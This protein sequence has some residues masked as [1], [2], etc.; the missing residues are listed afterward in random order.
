MN[1]Q[2][3]VQAMQKAQ[4][5]LEKEYKKLEEKEY[6]ASS[7]GVV[8]ITMKGDSSILSINIL[9]DDLL[10]P[11]NKEELSEMIILAYN[12][13]K[14]EI[15]KEQDEVSNKFKRQSGGLF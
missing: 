4:R 8:E 1:M 9:D 13:C 6:K 12:K 5:E 10:N 14:A 15:T 3:M 2:Q 11:E 7:N